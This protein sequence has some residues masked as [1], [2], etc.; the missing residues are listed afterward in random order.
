[1]KIADV[2]VTIWEWKNIPPTR[3][4]LQ[5]KSS[6]TRTA[7]MALVRIICDD[8][9]EGHAFLG[10]ALSSLGVGRNKLLASTNVF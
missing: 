3:Y 2:K 1:M 4:T 10:S 6:G 9:T 5:V 8:G 7:H